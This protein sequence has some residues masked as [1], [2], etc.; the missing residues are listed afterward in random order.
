MMIWF[1]CFYDFVQLNWVKTIPRATTPCCCQEFLNNNDRQV[2]I[3]ICKEGLHS[4]SSGT[5]VLLV[6][7]MLTGL[8]GYPSM[9]A[10]FLQQR[11][12]ASRWAD[13]IV[14]SEFVWTNR[15]PQL[16]FWF[17]ARLIGELSTAQNTGNHAK[18]RTLAF[19]N[20]NNGKVGNGQK[21]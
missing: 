16:Q 13:H 15:V 18:Y 20:I 6:A 10:N 1:W 3:E 21:S 5:Y 17:L 9:L 7:R 11:L 14:S 12:R 2:F 4:N 8:L 19:K